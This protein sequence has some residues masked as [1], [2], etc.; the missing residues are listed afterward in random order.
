MKD[1]V[2][3][4]VPGDIGVYMMGNLVVIKG[5]SNNEGDEKVGVW[6]NSCSSCCVSLGTLVRSHISGIGVVARGSNIV[7][8]PGD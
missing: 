6:C 4:P 5:S 3:V 8:E 2:P 7:V 1:A